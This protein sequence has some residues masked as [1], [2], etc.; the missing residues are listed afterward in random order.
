M[1]TVTDDTKTLNKNLKLKILRFFLSFSHLKTEE[2]KK[3]KKN[4]TNFYTKL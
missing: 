2:E 1:T 4:I 3:I